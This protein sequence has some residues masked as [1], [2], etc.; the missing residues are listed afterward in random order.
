MHPGSPAEQVNAASAA[1]A[2][3]IAASGLSA[4]AFWAKWAPIKPTTTPSATPAPVI[5]AADL[6]RL[7]ATCL[8]LYKA[9]AVTGDTHATSEACGAAIRASGMTSSDFWAKYH[10]A[11]N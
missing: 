4:T 6:A 7:I 2:K 1:C 8:D 3:A 11:T 10:P 5:S 9:M